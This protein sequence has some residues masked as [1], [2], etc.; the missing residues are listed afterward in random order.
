MKKSSS[1][2]VEDEFKKLNRALR[3]I[4]AC[5][6]AVQR[7]TDERA[8]L[9]QVCEAIVHVGKY[10]L[11]WVGLARQD[12]DKTVE[13][14]A[15]AGFES[16]YLNQINI[17]W[18]KGKRGRG[19]TGTAIRTGQAAVC[20]H[21]LLDA[22]FAPWRADALK[23]GYASAAALP[24]IAQD[25]VL[26]ALMI[27]SKEPDAFAIRETSLLQQ[28]ANDLAYGIITARAEAK[29]KRAEEQ[30]RRSEAYLAAGQRL[31]HAGSWAWNAV[32]QENAFWS[33]E[34]FRIY[35]FDVSTETVPYKEAH[36]RIHPQDQQL[37]D[38]TLAAAIRNRIDFDMIH[39]LLFPDGSIK[40]IHT[41]GHPVLDPSGNLMEY[42]GT[43][44]D[45]TEHKQAEETLRQTQTEL[46]RVARVTTVG[47]L[48]AS[49]A[50]EVNQP[51]AAVVTNGNACLRWLAAK[52]SNL[53][54][55]RKAVERIIRDANLASDVIARIR[56]LLKKGEQVKTRINANKIIRAMVALVEADARRHNVSVRT[57]LAA[58][59]P[60]VSGDR[61]Q[62]QQVLLNLVVNALDAMSTVDNG[63]RILQIETGRIRNEAIQIAVQDSGVGLNAQNQERL[64]EAFY[65][66]K[67]QGLGMGLSISRSIVES[68]GGRLWAMANEGP[69]ATFRFTLPI[70][71][72][73][74][75]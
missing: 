56:T 13:P 5:N 35:G 16:G 28:A 62:L 60:L 30:L 63:P 67:P 48:T 36:Q 53:D 31:S 58:N 55:A 8:L 49:I 68:H 50:H 73:G 52:P 44:M 51:L 6:R 70:K 7:S 33:E 2:H 37:F 20:Q 66:T 45:I 22:R 75:A 18:A 38:E 4:N 59:L 14:V 57:K 10:R 72:G 24:M 11:C 29:R 9:P 54:E 23:R 47:E 32:T 12:A 19:P 46:T 34:H 64:F 74:A 17:T 25:V 71:T 27:Y 1:Q 65:T 26:G 15:Q 3:I 69:G 21:I 40:Y 61:V 43:A 39:R 41:L 42:I